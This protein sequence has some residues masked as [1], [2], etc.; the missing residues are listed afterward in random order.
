MMGAQ[1]HPP[2]ALGLGAVGGRAR[3]PHARATRRRQCTDPLTRVPLVC[4]ANKDR[5]EGGAGPPGGLGSAGRAAE[6]L[7]ETLL[8]HL[9]TYMYLCNMHTQCVGS[10]DYGLSSWM[11]MPAPGINMRPTC[12]PFRKE[13]IVRGCVGAC[14]RAGAVRPT[15]HRRQKQEKEEKEEEEEAHAR[16]LETPAPG[17]ASRSGR[18]RGTHTRLGVSDGVPPGPQPTRS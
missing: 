6:P 14:G 11:C 12:R 4:A 8:R 17:L 18:G 15:R 3:T 9:P 13:P 7:L 1:S 10:N 16:E 5:Q 2:R